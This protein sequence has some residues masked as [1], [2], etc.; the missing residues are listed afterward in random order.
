MKTNYAAYLGTSHKSQQE[1]VRRWVRGA[2]AGRNR[3]ADVQLNPSPQPELRVKPSGFGSDNSNLIMRKCILLKNV[4]NPIL[5]QERASKE[6]TYPKN[7]KN[8]S[9]TF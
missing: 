1:I 2:E 3:P 6:T 4:G 5:L 7:D 9:R 8:E